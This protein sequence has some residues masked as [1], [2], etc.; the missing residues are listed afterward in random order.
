MNIFN[1]FK[2]RVQRYGLKFVMGVIIKNKIYRP[3][4]Q[5]VMRISKIIYRNCRLK[6]TIIIESHNDFDSNGGAFYDFLINHGYNNKYRIVWLLRNKKPKDLPSNVKGYNIFRPNLFKAYYICSAKY[7]I[8]CHVITEKVKEEQKSF[9]LTHGA[10]SLKAFKGNLILPESLDYYL[11]PSEFVAPIHAS[12]YML[13]YPN[14]KQ[15]ILGYPVHDVFYNNVKGDLKNITNKRFNK[16]ILWMPTFRAAVD[17]NRN[18]SS[19]E[20]PMGIP[21]IENMEAYE[22]INKLLQQHNSLLIIKIHPMQDM[23]RIKIKSLSNIIVL[24]GVSVKKLGVDN[25]RL[26]KD[27][28]ALISDYSS[29]AYDFLH[30]DRPIAY[31]LDDEKEYKIGF[32]VE[33][34]KELMAGHIIYSEEDLRL[35]IMEVIEEKDFYA[36]QRHELFNKI[37]KYHDGNSSQR[38]AEFIGLNVK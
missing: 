10:F 26:M 16:V 17:F 12:Q 27:S 20:L 28:D 19:A 35:F 34:P 9:Y 25:Y 4:D 6:N 38:L 8:S 22:K 11:C 23:T 29:T 5:V 7:L 2:T 14:K 37:F 32:L 31:T 1:K 3:L 21:V 13:E 36:K 18:D 30:L 24:D 15:L 33:N